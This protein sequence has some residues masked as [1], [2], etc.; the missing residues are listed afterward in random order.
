MPSFC[1]KLVHQPAW[2][3][4]PNP[5]RLLPLTYLLG[6]GGVRSE[7]TTVTIATAGAKIMEK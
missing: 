5:R 6:I 1:L 4:L 3:K 2:L 7:T